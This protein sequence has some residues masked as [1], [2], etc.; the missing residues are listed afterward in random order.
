MRVLREPIKGRSLK[1]FDRFVVDLCAIATIK[2]VAAF[3]GVGWDLVKGIS[4]RTCETASK[5][6]SSQGFVT[7]LWTNSRCAKGIDT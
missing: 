1:A 3:L 5:S 7:S 2:A 4:R 6:E